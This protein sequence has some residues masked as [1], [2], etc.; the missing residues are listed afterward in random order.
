MEHARKLEET[1]GY[2]DVDP[3][4]CWTEWQELRLELVAGEGSD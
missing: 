2:R 3:E 1:R 4:N